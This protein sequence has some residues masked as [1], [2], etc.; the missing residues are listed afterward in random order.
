MYILSDVLCCSVVQLKGTMIM[1]IDTY[2]DSSA[3]GRSCG[4]VVATTN[5]DFTRYHSTV[6]FQMTHQELQT[7]LRIAMTCGF[8]YTNTYLPFRVARPAMQSNHV[9]GIL[10]STCY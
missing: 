5:A 4:G 2:H 1:G 3:R 9:N 8:L 7:H 6:S 10:L